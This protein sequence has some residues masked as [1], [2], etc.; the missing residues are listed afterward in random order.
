MDLFSVVAVF[1]VIEA[2]ICGICAFLFRERNMTK[3]QEKQCK[4]TSHHS[5]VHP[6]HI[7]HGNDHQKE[8]SHAFG[9]QPK[10]NDNNARLSYFPPR[11]YP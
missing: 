1:L 7:T 8:W 4:R 9:Q 2:A 3:E 5:V 6:P 11:I 10:G